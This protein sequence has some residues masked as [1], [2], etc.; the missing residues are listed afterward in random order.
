MPSGGIHD[1]ERQ[2]PLLDPSEVERLPKSKIIVLTP[3]TN[4]AI[5]DTFHPIEHDAFCT[6]PPPP[7]RMLEIDERLVR[8]ED[9]EAAKSGDREHEAS[10][11]SN[12]P[13]DTPNPADGSTRHEEERA[14][15]EDAERQEDTHT[16][17]SRDE[18]D[19]PSDDGLSLDET[20]RGCGWDED[21]VA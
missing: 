7:R 1:D 6:T 20:D 18:V 9:Q 4:P 19:E 3:T 15:S 2:K 11:A 16:G 8:Q 14:V 5:L 17:W 21:Q 12:Q 10:N 13:V